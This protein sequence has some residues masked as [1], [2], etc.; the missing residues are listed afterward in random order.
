[1]RY[2][3]QG[4]NLPNE[5]LEERDN[6]KVVFFCGAGV[7]LNSGLPGFIDLAKQVLE[8][9]GAPEG[10]SARTLL[11]R[12]END[13]AFAPSLDQVFNL[14]QDEYG[15]GN[16]DNAVSQLLKS[17]QKANV[18]QHSVV[19]RLSRSAAHRPQLVT[20]NFDLLFERADKT[21]K[22]HIPPALPDL[23]SGQSLDGLVYLHG[24]RAT[25]STGGAIRQ[26]LII[27]S[28]DFGRAYLAD[29]WATK[30]VRDLVR[31]YI[32]VL[33]GYSAN[34]PPVRYL[35][36]G[37]HSRGDDAAARI[38]AFDQGT[39]LEVES[40][41][42]GRGV[43]HLA[44]PRSDSSHSAL[45][46]TL[47]S[48]ADRADDPAA[49]FH[50]VVS[51]AQSDPKELNAY[52]RGQVAAVISTNHGARLFAEADPPPPAEWMC[53]FDR[54]IRY[55]DPSKSTQNEKE[56]DPQLHYGLDDDPPRPK[57][58]PRQ[59]S[60]G[61]DFISLIA[62]DEKTS[63]QRRLA[64]IP[65]Q[66]AD[67]LP[68]RMFYL[69]S[70]FT[71]VLTD[72]VAAWWAAGYATLH[73]RL[74]QQIDWKLQ[75]SNTKIDS[76]ASA[77]WSILSEKFR[78]SPDDDI[79]LGW[80][81]FAA[82]LKRE[83][84]TNGVLR[85]FERVIR[86]FYSSERPSFGKPPPPSLPWSES[87]ITDVVY[88]D[89]KFPA[90]E[91]N[92]LTIP[93]EKL[94]D[95]FSALRLSLEYGCSLLADIEMPYW[96]TATLH[97]ENKPGNRHLDDADSYLHWTAALF[98]RLTLENPVRARVEVNQW[99]VDK[100][101]FDKLKIYSWMKPQLFSS[102]EVAS[103][104][105]GLSD[106]A[107]WASTHRRELLHTLRKRWNDFSTVAHKEIETR[108][109]GGPPSAKNENPADFA[110]RRSITIAMTLGWLQQQNCILSD[111]TL[112][113]LPNLR[114]AD[115]RWDASWDSSAD[116][117]HEGRASFVRT[118]SDP[119]NIIDA[120]LPELLKRAQEQTVRN[121]GE[122]VDRQ[123]FRG[124]VEQKPFR[125]LAALSRE[126]REG[127]YPRPFW[128]LAISHW[129][130]KT[131]KRLR[132]LFAHRLARLP[133]DEIVELRHYVPGWLKKN[134]PEIAQS[135]PKDALK[136]WDDLVSTFVSSGPAATEGG[137]GDTLIAGKPQN[138]S[139]KTYSHAINSPVGMLTE[140]LFDILDGLKLAAGEGIPQEF[141]ARIE[142]SLV[143]PGEGAAHAI[144]EIGRR[145]RWLFYLDPTWVEKKIVP[146]FKLDQESAEP[147]WNGYLH[148]TELPI[149]PLFRQLKE[150]FL[151]LPDYL[152]RWKW[153]DSTANRFSEL[154]VLACFWNKA[155]GE[156]VT[157]NEC[158]IA[159]QHMTDEDRAH[160]IWFVS[161][162]IKDQQAWKSFGKPFIQ[163]AW[164]RESRMQS[165]STSRQFIMLATNADDYFRETVQLILPLLTQGEH[166]DLSVYWFRTNDAE[167]KSELVK[168]YPESVLA[169]V[170]RLIPERPTRVPY[171]LSALLN[172][173]TESDPELRQNSRWK[174]LNDI[175]L[176]G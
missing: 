171:E 174:R 104:L 170:D 82:K 47:K 94:S 120:P 69:A 48:W 118:E 159:L 53:V 161:K 45:W 153:G 7:S 8:S 108:I 130:E 30:F 12:A 126:A 143:A 125:A 92:K 114:A 133:K 66:W 156:Y 40:R 155:S 65:Q 39:E 167:G 87:K 103:G 139:H 4:P 145:I 142:Q 25:R 132:W 138:R 115:A 75:N 109:V 93:K 83:G 21:I 32:I 146:L 147:A 15:A 169:M 90:Q 27:S 173:I 70:W 105:L 148:D 3:A 57:S 37:L 36:E 67:P 149:A 176:R 127:K 64:G 6:G 50:S 11:A 111:E 163:R 22:T 33:L 18:E 60:V 20:T 58:S 128:Q 117:S 54:N 101:F 80:H 55:A 79:S 42:R 44:Y 121:F 123:P 52:E 16:V 41:W 78:N 88:F 73:P 95:V 113:L 168:K 160:A 165:A 56:F 135:S 175:V 122:F 116:D 107:F 162:I 77:T 137:L 38:Y 99:P 112:S 89:V 13:P 9:F 172:I 43:T 98:D 76:L 134:L 61:K 85:E 129:P 28:P 51:R 102:E 29:G 141:Q 63:D 35:L 86:P 23:A 72:P 144:C 96:R 59:Q 131:S 106:E 46:E 14:L 119:S 24:R 91:I 68:P 84:W 140:A 152:A 110:R 31:R 164:P 2:F 62:Q 100:F 150:S 81:L 19:L 97:P 154:L 34:D 136:I 49:W 74:V 5:L 71:K 124:V 17:P 151:K 10:S 26:G 166:A 1:M 157:F 158:R